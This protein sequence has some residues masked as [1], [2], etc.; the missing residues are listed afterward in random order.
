MSRTDVYTVSFSFIDV[1]FPYTVVTCL[2][3]FNITRHARVQG[4][5]IAHSPNCPLASMDSEFDIIPGLRYTQRTS[6]SDFPAVFAGSAK[7]FFARSLS[8][9]SLN[10]P[11]FSCKLFKF[12]NAFQRWIFSNI[13]SFLDLFSFSSFS[14]PVFI[15]TLYNLIY[16]IFPTLLLELFRFRRSFRGLFK[17]TSFRY[18][19]LLPYR[20]RIWSPTPRIPSQLLVHVNQFWVFR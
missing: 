12:S 8:R 2:F 16:S 5:L 7:K 6:F 20:F 11:G 10:F 3:L 15:C 9:L 4:S 18:S 17:F 13:P 14:F 1:F 19:Q